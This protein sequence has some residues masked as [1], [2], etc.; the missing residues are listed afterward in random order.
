MPHLHLPA[1]HSDAD[2]VLAT[3]LADVVGSEDLYVAWTH[4]AGGGAI[5]EVEALIRERHAPVNPVAELWAALRAGART[6][7]RGIVEGSASSSRTPIPPT[8]HGRP[9]A[10]GEPSA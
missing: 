1:E 6:L 4:D 3:T 8:V 5:P 9:H 7:W 10:A 2:L